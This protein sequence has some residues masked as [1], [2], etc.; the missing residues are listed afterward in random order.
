M[1]YS[2]FKISNIHE[3]RI[4]IKFFVKP[5][6]PFTEL[7]KIMQNS[8]D[9]QYLRRTQCYV[10]FKHFKDGWMS[11]D[12]DSRDNAHMKKFMKLYVIRDG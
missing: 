7:R 12:E 9:D 4:H 3:Q 11:I 6:K 10:W 8:Y 5:V 1:C 2:I